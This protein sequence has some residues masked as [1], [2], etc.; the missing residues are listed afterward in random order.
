MAVAAGALAVAEN[1]RAARYGKAV[2]CAIA[3]LSCVCWIVILYLIARK[4]VRKMF[5]SVG[6]AKI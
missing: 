6:G 2:A 4:N 5:M 1:P 3:A